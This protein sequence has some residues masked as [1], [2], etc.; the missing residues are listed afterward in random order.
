MVIVTVITV[1]V[2]DNLRTITPD[3]FESVGGFFKASNYVLRDHVLGQ[4]QRIRI[5]RP[6]HNL[7]P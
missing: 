7:A 4:A 1:N 3:R 6:L 2:F 5:S